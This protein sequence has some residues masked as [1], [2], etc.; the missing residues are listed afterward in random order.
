MPDPFIRSASGVVRLAAL[1]IP[2]VEY[3]TI[4][5]IVPG[6]AGVED[7]MY[8]CLKAKDNNYHWVATATGGDATS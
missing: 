1:P 5:V 8:I 4:F 6:G 7:T 3:S 2:G